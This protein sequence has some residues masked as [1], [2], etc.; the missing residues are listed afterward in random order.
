[1]SEV[2]IPFA[3]GPHGSEVPIEEAIRFKTDYY[4]CP[5]CQKF[6]N[7]RKGEKRQ[8]YAHGQGELNEVEC[9]LSSD[10]DV[11]RMVDGLRTSDVE[12]EES[13]NLIR[14]YIGEEPG[15][16]HRLFGV[17]P[18]MERNHFSPGVEIEG[19]IN[20]CNVTNTTGIKYPP[21]S[22]SFHPSEPEVIF[23]LDPEKDEYQLSFAG[24]SLVKNL[25]GDWT[26]ETLQEGDIFV[27]DQTRAR[28]FRSNRQVKN[29]EWV[30]IVTA[31]EPSATGES[32]S[33]HSLGEWTLLA[34]PARPETADLLDE[35][36]T[37]LRTDDYGFDADVLMPAEAHPTADKPIIAEPG[38]TVLIGV[39]P[40]EEL[41][42]VF[43]I[44][45]IPKREADTD[46]LEP[47]GPG[48]TRFHKTKMPTR[49]SKRI[50][51]H[52]RNSSRHRLIHLHAEDRTDGI[53]PDGL[54]NGEVKLQYSGENQSA[55]LSPLE[56][57]SSI[58][59]DENVSP[60]SL[61]SSLEYI[62]FSGIEVEVIAYF[63]DDHPESP[64]IRRS[65]ES[66]EAVFPNVGHWVTQGCTEAKFAFDG[67]GSVS[68]QF[69]QN[70]EAPTTGGKGR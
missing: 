2:S 70:I 68:L 33:T 8:Y 62:G 48:N 12:Q 60:M 21:T 53:V 24:P 1:M 50:S 19:T 43:E 9:E 10:Q 51:V 41:D 20:Q 27:G 59:I 17:I 65:P 45:S 22:R 25:T 26:T 36:G 29:G 58:M 54:L 15:G 39:T 34:F 4:K 40:A 47:T 38:E 64:L 52:Q 14:T 7:P 30:Y 66:V 6:V 5:E 46:Q 35:Y 32:V 3:L 67:I 42:P 23:D 11:E 18:S 16:R 31:A 44:V 63:P 61:P 37:G 28:R 55:R 56:E 69:K 13:Q 49:G 57:D